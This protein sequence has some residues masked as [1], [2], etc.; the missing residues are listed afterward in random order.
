MLEGLR[1]LLQFFISSAYMEDQP[2][3]RNQTRP[4]GRKWCRFINAPLKFRDPSSKIW[5]A[6]TSTLDHFFA[7]SAFDTAYLRNETKHE[8]TKM[9]VSI[10]YSTMRPIQ[11]DLLPVT[12]DPET[13]E[14]RLLTVTQ[15]SSTITLQPSCNRQ[16]CDFFSCYYY[17]YYY[18]F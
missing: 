10:Y 17:Y 5:G 7:T 4:V 2:W 8:Q 9:L 12:F 1:G 11:G 18:Y 13:A 16:S 3:D 14:I 15:H 6:K